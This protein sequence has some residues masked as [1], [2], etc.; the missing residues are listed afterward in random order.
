VPLCPPHQ[1]AP[2]G[3]RSYLTLTPQV[4]ASTARRG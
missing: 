4:H 2:A 3:P 1:P